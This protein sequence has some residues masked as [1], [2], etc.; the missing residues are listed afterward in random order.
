MNVVI[1]THAYTTPQLMTEA[2][3]EE[4]GLTRHI[5]ARGESLTMPEH[6]RNSPDQYVWNGQE[7]QYRPVGGKSNY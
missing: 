7:W 5:V 1:R 6:V 4:L 2:R 3:A